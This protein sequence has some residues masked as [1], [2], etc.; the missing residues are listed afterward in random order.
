MSSK[1]KDKA[2]SLI[3]CPVCFE[4]I[5]AVLSTRWMEEQQVTR[6]RRKCL[7]CGHKFSTYETSD[8]AVIKLENYQKALERIKKAILE[9]NRAYLRLA[10]YLEASGAD[11][12]NTAAAARQV[13]AHLRMLGEDVP[14]FSRREQRRRDRLG[15]RDGDSAAGDAGGADQGT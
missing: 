8:K 15:I 14:K 3:P 5:S 2:R 9:A 11:E 4:G 1:R 12:Q 6:R 7:H 13:R 10:E